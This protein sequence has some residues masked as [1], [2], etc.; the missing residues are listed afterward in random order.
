[1]VKP[2]RFRAL[3]AG[4]FM[5]PDGTAPKSGDWIKCGSCG[6]VFTHMPALDDMIEEEFDETAIQKEHADFCASG[7]DLEAH[8]GKEEDCQGDAEDRTI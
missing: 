7:G 1:M 5:F 6:E 3:L 8:G 2:E 4:D